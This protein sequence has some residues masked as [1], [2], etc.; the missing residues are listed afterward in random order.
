MAD[1]RQEASPGSGR[2]GTRNRPHLTACSALAWFLVLGLVPGFGTGGARA[3]PP[4][5]AATTPDVPDLNPP[6]GCECADTALS[7]IVKYFSQHGFPKLDGTPNDDNQ[8]I[9]DVSKSHPGT[10]PESAA[11]SYIKDKGY[12]DICW[13]M[14]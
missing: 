9:R 13:S 5:G 12:Q 2:I 4:A 14:R 8:L 11:K 1:V 10:D 3:D 7:N 6:A